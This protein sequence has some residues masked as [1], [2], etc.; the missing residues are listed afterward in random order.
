V[1]YK[2]QGNYINCWESIQP[3]GYPQMVPELYQL[4]IK[5]SLIERI[6]AGFGLL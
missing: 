3:D 2:N 5:V 4:V 6:P 1:L